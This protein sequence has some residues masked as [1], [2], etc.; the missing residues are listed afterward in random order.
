M[1]D[2]SVHKLVPKHEILNKKEKEDILNKF[3]INEEKLPKIFSSDPAIK[4]M[5][6]KAGAVIKITR[7]SITAGESVYYRVVVNK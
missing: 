5:N 4:N 2:T 1:I 6:V 3:E 7:D